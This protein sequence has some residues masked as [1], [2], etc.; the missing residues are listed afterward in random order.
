[1]GRG[2][3][4][5]TSMGVRVLVV[6]LLFFVAP[7]GASAQTAEL[8][9]QS[10]VPNAI[11]SVDGQEVATTG[12]EGDVLVEGLA[13]G[14]RTIR[15]R[16]PGY[17]TASTQTRLDP[18]LTNVVSLELAARDVEAA[19]LL[20]ETNVPEAEVVLDGTQRAETGADGQAS[21]T[22]VDPGR[23]RLVVRKEG[24]ASAARTVS[25]SG[26]VSSQ[27]VQ[28]RLEQEED[29]A[30][31]TEGDPSR[32]GTAVRPDSV[33]LE[34]VTAALIPDSMALDSAA[35]SE[36]GEER[37]STHLA[38]SANVGGAQVYVDGT[39]RGTTPESGTLEVD[40]DPGQFQVVLQK[41]GFPS[42][43]RTGRLAG[44]ETRTLSFTL[45]REEP[46]SAFVQS[47]SSRRVLFGAGGVAL[48]ALVVVVIVGWRR[49]RP[50]ATDEDLLDR[51][52][53]LEAIGTEG[54]TTLYRAEDRAEDREVVLKVL[55]EA[56]EGDSAVVEA[57]L[58]H[59][60]ALRH[61][62]ASAPD[63]P[64]VKAFRYGREKEWSRK[65]AFIELEYVR[66]ERLSAYLEQH[67]FDVRE[68]L[69]VVRQVCTGM[70]VAH[71]RQL[72]HGHL[73]PESV[74]VTDRDPKIRVKLVDFQVGA[75]PGRQKAPAPPSPE[76]SA[77]VAPEQRRGE[78]IDGRTD[79]YAAGMLFY[80]MM[81]GH[82]P[83]P[84]RASTG[85]PDREESVSLPHLSEVPPHVE[86]L[87]R[88]MLD[89]DPEKRPAASKVADVINLV[90]ETT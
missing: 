59:G 31:G 74:I 35:A 63:A 28:V 5:P 41:D 24:Y 61:I 75:G 46:T 47:L 1:M 83:A 69:T 62:A 30:S 60:E 15:L 64:V 55:D 66:G 37:A 32:G 73:T 58:E 57:F 77:Y 49:R 22:N 21:L 85:D 18:T 53:V 27:T 7:V 51:Y 11:V 36:G 42:R 68:A 29:G 25:V 80:T 40:V 84:D 2:R 56:Y 70:Q 76:D 44:G 67:E 50:A 82:P 19:D 12:A 87:F 78:T 38:V 86:S 81:M 33:T 10:N 39:Y 26:S 88:R 71:D 8:F 4:V 43:Q 45:R 20:V 90:R 65:R 23:H 3:T 13:P 16:K 72:W 17:W 54:I 14:R 9:L 34:S 79:V 48:V 52:R 6:V 89:A